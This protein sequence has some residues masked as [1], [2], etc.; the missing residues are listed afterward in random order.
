MAR[1]LG[2]LVANT[3]VATPQVIDQNVTITA[4]F[5]NATNREEIKEAFGD[6]VNLAA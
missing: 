6:L 2:N 4:E 3:M 1:G 5:P